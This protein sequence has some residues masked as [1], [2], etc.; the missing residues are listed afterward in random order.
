MPRL[1]EAAQ[2]ARTRPEG[3]QKLSLP[4]AF[5]RFLHL[6]APPLSGRLLYRDRAGNQ[7]KTSACAIL[8]R[9]EVHPDRNPA[10]CDGSGRA[11]GIF[12]RRNP[13]GAMRA[14]LTPFIISTYMSC[15]Y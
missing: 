2:G 12:F 15:A 8:A 9:L 5:R 14:A 3:A 6:P 11:D 10:R 1:A 7:P 4:G 13:F